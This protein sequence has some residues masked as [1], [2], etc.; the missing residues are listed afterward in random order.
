MLK[1]IIAD[2]ERLIRES[3]N[4]L[5]DWHSVGVEV[6]GIAS[7]GITALELIESLKPDILLSDI[8]MPNLNGIELIKTLKEKNIKCEIIFLSAY[9]NFEYAQSA[10]R[11]GAF[12]YIL[13]P[14]DEDK[15]LLSVT[16]CAA[17]IN[18]IRE[19]EEALA[20]DNEFQS[21]LATSAIK[22]LLYTPMLPTEN[23]KRI[24]RE[25]GIV[26]SQEFAASGICLR[27]NC[28]QSQDIKFLS[29][30][31][32]SEIIKQYSIQVSNEEYMIIGVTN[33]GRSD[34]LNTKM[35]TLLSLVQHTYS[36]ILIGA[37]LSAVHTTEDIKKIYPEC[38]FALLFEKLGLE[39]TKYRFWDAA[40][41]LS[42]S[43]PHVY[44]A[45]IAKAIKN[46]D[47]AGMAALLSTLFWRFA[48]REQIYDIDSVKLKCLSLLDALDGDLHITSDPLTEQE[49][50]MLT[51][52]KTSITKQ[53]SLDAIYDEM[54]V[55]LLKYAQFIKNKE[56][57]Q[58]IRLVSQTVQYIK[59]CYATATL[60]EAASRMYI[61]P[62][63]LS[64]IFA[65]EMKE[66]F[67][68]FVLKY[69]I[70]I[71]KELLLDPQYKVYDV[72][73]LVGY[74]DIANFS[75]AFKQIEGISPIKFKNHVIST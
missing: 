24:L 61:T 75:K 22:N 58:S 68:H 66:T 74:S 13:K 4:K 19:K 30:P 64:R 60:T 44:A 15:L 10:I 37:S 62:S 50:H 65:T 72:A 7:D 73:N 6:V 49:N 35:Y 11:Y 9:S 56:N 54:S 36:H 23:E 3:L 39:N 26:Q 43:Y 55:T 46:D 59:E 51:T 45:D 28:R 12:D 67:S 71:A 47:L 27:F 41:Q 48:A 69:R 20:T 63:Y 8:A 17:K 31:E 34:M 18:S 29:L 1:M 32:A 2:D 70:Q 5:M 16:N 21:I 38:C 33:I 42:L 40:Q 25:L 53:R 52:A 14:I 57:F